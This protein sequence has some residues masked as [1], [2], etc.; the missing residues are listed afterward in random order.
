MVCRID[1]IDVWIVKEG[2][3]LGYSDYIF[4]V[5]CYVMGCLYLDVLR[6][7]VVIMELL[8][9]GEFCSVIYLVRMGC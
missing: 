3:M 2:L 1:I 6:S 7:G 5:I 9:K 8:L 4:G